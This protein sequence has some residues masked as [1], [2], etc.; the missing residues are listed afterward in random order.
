MMHGSSL[1][2]HHEKEDNVTEL[3]RGRIRCRSG[4]FDPTTANGGGTAL[5][6]IEG[7]LQLVR[8]G[9]RRGYRCMDESSWGWAP[10]Y[11]GGRQGEGSE[12]ATG[13]RQVECL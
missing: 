5:V 2:L 13:R 11:S 12:E 8:R 1:L 9:I 7:M 4:C 3:T 6:L 10:F